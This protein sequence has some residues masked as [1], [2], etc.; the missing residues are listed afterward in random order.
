MYGTGV[1]K[2]YNTFKSYQYNS[3]DINFEDRWRNKIG[4]LSEPKRKN[5]KKW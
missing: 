2:E 3:I 1:R 4:K 5:R